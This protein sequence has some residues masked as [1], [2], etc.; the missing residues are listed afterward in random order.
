MTKLWST[1][2][3]KQAIAAIMAVAFTVGGVLTV[4]TASG[5]MP[6]AVA[7][8]IDNVTR[9][10]EG[11][12]LKAYRDAV[13]VPTICDGDTQNVKMGMVETQAGCDARLR[14]RMLTE[15]YPALQACITGFDGKP[16]SWQAMM[17]DLSWNIG[18]GGTCKSTA[19][20]LGREGKYLESCYAATKF[21]RAGGKVLIGLVKR[22]E[23][24]DA[25][26]IGEGEL[27]VSGLEGV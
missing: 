18:H 19:A 5:Q 14:R 4:N 24:G 13:G 10:W 12:E 16:I 1:T 20:R 9:P 2:R 25:T 22:R 23:M 3:A 15:F 17:I 21:N 6:A 11:R 7:L 27:C 8:A 26:R